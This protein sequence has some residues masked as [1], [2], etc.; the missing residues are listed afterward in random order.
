MSLEINQDKKQLTLNIRYA[1]AIL[2]YKTHASSGK[3]RMS[4]TDNI[5]VH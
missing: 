5:D 1:T 2:K 4:M 3:Q